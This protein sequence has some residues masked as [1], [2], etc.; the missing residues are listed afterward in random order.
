L[1]TIQQTV[2]VNKKGKLLH[3]RNG[4]GGRIRTYGTRDQNPWILLSG[5]I[6]ILISLL[7]S[8]YPSHASYELSGKSRKLLSKIK[9][10]S[11]QRVE[12]SLRIITYSLSLT[13]T[14]N[15]RY[16]LEKNV[17]E[18]MSINGEKCI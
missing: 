9:L 4:W 8:S 1:G 15:V 18:S 3:L 16:V 11:K 13:G 14:K 6:R 2:K 17:I 12:V 5:V 7:N 10:L